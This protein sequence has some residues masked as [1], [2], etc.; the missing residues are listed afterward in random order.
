M[1][2]SCLVGQTSICQV[3]SGRAEST[4]VQHMYQF[5]RNCQPQL[6]NPTQPRN[7]TKWGC[8]WAGL[9]LELG[10]AGLNLVQY[11]A[12]QLS[13]L[14][15]GQHPVHRPGNQVEAQPI[16][17]RKN[18][19]VFNMSIRSGS[20]RYTTLPNPMQVEIRSDLA[21]CHLQQARFTTNPTIFDAPY[22]SSKRKKGEETR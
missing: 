10:Q 8:S 15:S 21:M 13:T 6:L 16:C 12:I 11:C 22:W 1:T 4:G 9:N 18:L 20:S 2:M 7:Q 17:R 5:G 3:R 19:Y 14:Y